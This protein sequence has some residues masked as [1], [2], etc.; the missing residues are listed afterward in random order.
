MMVSCS[1]LV[2]IL[3]IYNVDFGFFGYEFGLSLKRREFECKSRTKG[4]CQVGP[5]DP[6]C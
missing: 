2:L 1:S 3:G 5:L 6:S 4:I